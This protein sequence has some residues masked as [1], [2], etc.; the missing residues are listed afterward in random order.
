[1][2]KIC[3]KKEKGRIFLYHTHSFVN[4]CN[5]KLIKRYETK[6]DTSL[7]IGA[8]KNLFALVLEALWGLKHVN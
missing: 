3:T 8:N 7:T 5:K 6:F 4:L 2:I 1:M